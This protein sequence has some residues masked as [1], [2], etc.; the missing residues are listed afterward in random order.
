VSS[1]RLQTSSLQA[2]HHN[3]RRKLV[4]VRLLAEGLVLLVRAVG[5]WGMWNVGGDTLSSQCGSLTAE[6]S[7]IYVAGCPV[8]DPSRRARREGVFLRIH[9]L[10]ASVNRDYLWGPTPPIGH[11]DR[12][13]R[14]WVTPTPLSGGRS[15]ARC[16][17]GRRGTPRL[18]PRDPPDRIASPR[19][20]LGCGRARGV[21]PVRTLACGRLLEYRLVASAV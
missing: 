4:V 11:E 17:R 15:N 21:P 1:A 3:Q 5:W 14:H 19:G 18:M 9:L 6:R 16:R 7:T 13:V 12:T 10:G 20:A 8:L 2:S